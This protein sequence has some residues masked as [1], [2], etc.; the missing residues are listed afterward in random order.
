MLIQ[1]GEAILY[2]TDLPFEERL[3]LVQKTFTQNSDVVIIKNKTISI[4][5]VR[6]FQND[7]QKSSSEI[8]KPC[9]SNI[10][11]ILVKHK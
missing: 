10:G 5:E 7:F 3:D 4:D 6:D 1:K 9:F 8:N 2:K 11:L